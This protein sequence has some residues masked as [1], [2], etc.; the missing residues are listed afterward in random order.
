M[1]DAFK[2]YIDPRG[3]LVYTDKQEGD[4]AAFFYGTPGADH[5]L[6]AYPHDYVL[7]G[8]HTRGADLVRKD[9]HWQ[10]IGEDATAALFKRAQWNPGQPSFGAVAISLGKPTDTYF[11]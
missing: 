3:E 1:G 6:E 5:L 7:M 9:P 2:V 11:P 8:V 4:Y 10:L